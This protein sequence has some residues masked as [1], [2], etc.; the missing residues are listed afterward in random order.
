MPLRDTSKN[1]LLQVL[2]LIK[3]LNEDG[4]QAS[5]PLLQGQSI[6]RHLRHVLE[7]FALLLADR[8]GGVVNYDVRER[9]KTLE[10]SRQAARRKTEDLLGRI[11]LITHDQTLT[12]EVCFTAGEGENIHVPTSLY[13][14]LAY[15]IE[16]AIH[17][18]AIVKIAIATHYPEVRLPE[19]FGVAPSTMRH[20]HNEPDEIKA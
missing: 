10:S 17:H 1:I 19:E 2:Q 15:N 16:H 3:Q 12:L 13:R 18:L 11:D 20:R 7:I 8:S 6:G 5:L 9:D 14:E 4:F